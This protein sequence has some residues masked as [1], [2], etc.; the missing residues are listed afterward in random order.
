VFIALFSMLRSSVELRGATFL[1]IKDLSQP[2]TIGHI[3][4]FPFNPLPLAMGVSM[5]WQM[6]LT[7]SGGDP[8]QQQ[9]MMFMPLMMLFFFYSSASGLVLYWTIQQ[10]LSIGQQWWSMRQ[11]DA[12]APA[13]AISS[14]GKTK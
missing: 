13:V 14:T 3:L 1:W 10:F 12:M 8:K 6:K 4:G 11:P 5:I 7:P 9:M 2:D